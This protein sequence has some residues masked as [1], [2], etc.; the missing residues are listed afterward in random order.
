MRIAACFPG[1]GSQTAGM[2]GSVLELPLTRRLLEVAAAEGLDLAGALAGE[3]ETL[4]ATEIAQPALLLVGVALFTQLPDAVEV[5]GVAGHSVGEYAA[6][7]AAGSLDAASA[8]RLV[9]ARGHAMA[10]MRE[11]TMAALLGV[12]QQLADAVCAE[13]NASGR[14]PVVIA[15]LNAPGQVV[16]SGSVSGVEAALDLARA[17][18][19]RKALPLRVSGAFHSPLMAEAAATVGAL[20][21]AT[22]LRD[23]RVP[24]ACNVD[25]ALVHG[26]EELRARL[27]RQLAAPV[28]WQD[29]ITAL[30]GLG[31]EAL[32]ELGPGGVLTGLARRIVP[33]VRALNARTAEEAAQ[34]GQSVASGS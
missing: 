29:C 16:L 13:V 31:V 34:L 15:N 25:G 22:P 19:V 3:D 26:A 2:A 33:D 18:G 28:Y 10:A 20:I 9:I 7:V 11:G 4:R 27:R 24:V 5:V 21:D 23:A 1:Q 17:R 14:G 8:M 30:A 12:D 6:L 32:V